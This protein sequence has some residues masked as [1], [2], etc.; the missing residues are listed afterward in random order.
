MRRLPL[1]LLML[2]AAAAQQPD[3]RRVDFGQYQNARSLRADWEMAGGDWSLDGGSLKGGSVATR[4]FASYVAMPPASPIEVQATL[5]V[6][7]RLNPSSWVTTGVCIYLDSGAFW[8]LALVEG[9]DQKRYAELVEMHNGTWQAQREGVTTLQPAQ[10]DGQFDAWEYGH[11]Y[12]LRL[13]LDDHEVRGEITD[14]TT[15]RVRTTLAYLWGDAPGVKEGRP[16]LVT[17]GFSTSFQD[18]QA[19]AEPRTATAPALALK[20]GARGTVLLSTSTRVEGGRETVAAVD[21]ALTAAGFGVNKVGWA[22]LMDPQVLEPRQ[23]DSLVLVDSRGYPPDGYPALQRFL[24]GGG[25]LVLLGGRAFEQPLYQAGGDYLTEAELR[26]VAAQSP[27]QAVLFDFEQGV[28][29]W[30][31]VSNAPDSGS[32]ITTD[33]GPHGRCAR[34]QVKGLSGWDNA[35]A[36]FPR[37]QAEDANAVSIWLKADAATPTVAMELGEADGSRWITSV[38]VTTDW[39]RYVIP[40]WQFGFWR[41]SRSEGRGGE[42]D[43]VQLSQVRYLNVGQAFSH[44]GRLPGDHTIWFDQIGVAKV[45][46]P[47]VSAAEALDLPVFSDYEVYRF[48]RSTAVVSP[49]QTILPVLGAPLPLG[50]GGWSAIGFAFPNESRYVSLLDAKDE[51]GRVSGSALGLLANCRGRYRDSVWLFS[52][53]DDQRVY[54]TPAFLHA[55][56]AALSSVISPE[57]TA[58]YRDEMLAPVPDLKLTTPAPHAGY[59]QKSADGK[60]LVYP[61]G[62]RFFMIGCNYVGHFD[63]C[64][65]RMWRDDFYDPRVVEQDFKNARDAGLN[66]MR[67]WLQTTIDEDLRRGDTRKITAIRE[68]ARKYG[69][70]LLIDLPGTTYATEQDMVASHRAIA[71]A[72]ADEPMVLGYDLRNEP[73]VTTIG[74]IRYQ[75][76]P[77]PVQSHDLR[78]DFPGQVDT[79]AIRS[80]I[81]ERPYWLHLPGWLQGEEAERLTSA[82]LLWSQYLRE[83]QLASSTLNGLTATPPRTGWEPLIDAVDTSLDRW[84]KVQIEAIR[85]V[86]RNHLI[87]VGHNTALT[88]LPANAQLDFVSE[89]IYARPYS[90]GNVIENITTLDRLAERWP[91]RPITLGE[92]GYSNGIKL[93]DGYLDSQ[94]SAVG[95]MIHYLYALS[96]GYDGVK[97]WMLCDW[98]LAVMK[99]YGDWDRGLETRIYEERFG[100]Y[101]YDGTPSGRPKPIVPT[102]RFLRDYVEDAGPGGTLDVHAAENPIGTAYVY[103]GQ[104]AL[105]I[106]DASYTDDTLSFTAPTPRNVMLRWSDDGFTIMAAGDTTVRLRPG[107]LVPGLTPDMAKVGQPA[108]EELVLSLLAGQTVTV[109]R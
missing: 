10:F 45:D 17:Y 98:P 47:R 75:G 71:Q 82:W 6:N 35:Q 68:C 84:L 80:W 54:R 11:P 104:N 24:R 44:T 41:D 34:F 67:Y 65:G 16:A 92:F 3:V 60:H 19:T 78:E 97:K 85:E 2:S 109:R 29:D 40:A 90:F 5:T 76:E 61:D 30:T 93:N 59:I 38:D 49:G 106:G 72:F 50:D 52:G 57:L 102:L 22:P 33:A 73:Y 86:D 88:M 4:S 81:A 94:T 87:T 37:E 96:H 27:D 31:R 28:A 48:G 13:K 66:V 56:T 39:Q 55:L 32:A 91:E 103:R 25:D 58:S 100:L 21:E 79:A 20:R 53:L 74:G 46:L 18:L 101:S 89:H 51:A 83:H 105:F 99:R 14:V 70:Y 64:G 23:V 9:P 77:V 1:V 108:G 63:R 43:T 8:Q 95:E 26:Q 69:V 36:T 15:G 107:K 12:R 42:G 62:R 7:R